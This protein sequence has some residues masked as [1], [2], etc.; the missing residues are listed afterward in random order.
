VS[1]AESHRFIAMR[2]CSTVKRSCSGLSS[3]RRIL[4][5]REHRTI[6]SAARRSNDYAFKSVERRKKETMQVKQ[7]WI[8]AVTEDRLYPNRIISRL[9]L[10]TFVTCFL[11]TTWVLGAERSLVVRDATVFNSVTKKMTPGQTVVIV[12]DRI[13]K[14]GPSDSIGELPD[15]ARVIEAKGKFVI[16][17]LIDAHAHLTFPINRA[18]I[19]GDEILPLFLAAGVTA[20]RST[21]GEVVAET[22]V[23]HYA[24]SHPDICPRVFTASLLFDTRPVTHPELSIPV[25]D[26]AQ[27]REIVANMVAWKVTTLK[28]Y[29]RLSPPVASE[30]IRQGHHHGLMVTAHLANN[31]SAQQAV[32]DG[33]DCLE[34]IESVFNY[35][36]FPQKGLEKASREEKRANLDL[37]NPRAKALIVALAQHQVMVSP[38][39][40]VFRNMLLLSDLEEVHKHPDNDRVPQRLK[41]YWDG[42]RKIL[43]LSPDTLELRR[44]KF[45]KYQEL[46]GILHRAGVPL[47]VGTDTPEPYCP[48]GWALHQEMELMVQ[49][50]L[51]PAEVLAAAT[52][53]NAH[54]LKMTEHLGSVEPSK[55]ADLVIL[56]A[57][58]T[59]DITNSRRIHAVIRSGYVCDREKA[60]RTVPKQ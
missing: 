18:H 59:V 43:G 53:Q 26:P 44:K 10:L 14:V 38:T 36:Q 54:A 34:H 52:L 60:F 49:S 47:L 19:T 8:S 28:I 12:G 16:P 15:D 3:D 11:T 2:T 51:T 30:V 9:S 21:G 25:T 13:A 22:G 37:N 32:A 6:D 58:P 39:L 29:A 27:V 35:I 46:T 33:I 57:D 24:A 40:T 41:D 5:V 56:D 48:P 1:A 45:A 55:L 20:V 7:S 17:G 23:A 42:Y 50:G 31:Y 4:G